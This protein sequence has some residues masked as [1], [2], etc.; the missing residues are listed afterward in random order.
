M[1]K[2]NVKILRRPDMDIVEDYI[3]S[4]YGKDFCDH[5]KVDE[6]SYDNSIYVEEIIFDPFDIINSKDEYCPVEG[7][8]LSPFDT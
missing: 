5:F 7:L 2:N 1:I 6:T 3:N 8:G 4:T